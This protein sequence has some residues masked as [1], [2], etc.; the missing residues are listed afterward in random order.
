MVFKKACALGESSLGFGRVKKYKSWYSQREIK[1]LY[2]H[3]TM[4]PPLDGWWGSHWLDACRRSQA[5]RLKLCP[6]RLN[7]PTQPS[8]LLCF[9]TANFWRGILQAAARNLLTRYRNKGMNRGT[10]AFTCAGLFSPSGSPDL[11]GRI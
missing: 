9:T 1:E 7:E 4:N 3:P 8:G 2:D 6:V 11:K 5:R 10:G